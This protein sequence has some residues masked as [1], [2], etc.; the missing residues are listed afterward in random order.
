MSVRRTLIL[1]VLLV[2]ILPAAVVWGYPSLSAANSP[3]LQ[4][5]VVSES[6]IA[7]GIAAYGT[8]EAEEIVNLSFQTSGQV[9]EVLVEDGDWVQAG[10]A[11]IRVDSRT[12]YATYEQANLNYELAVRQLE[13]LQTPDDDAISIAEANLRA[14]QS[15]YADVNNAITDE[16]IAAAQLQYDQAQEALTAAQEARQYAN[17]NVQSDETI[18]LMDAQI[19]EASFNAEIA[20][21]RVEELQTANQGELGAAWA[22]VLQAQAAL[23]Q[24]QSGVTEYQIEQAENAVE[25]AQLTLDQAQ[26]NYDRTMLTAPFD[27][28]VADVTVEVGQRVS[29]GVP[30]VQLVDVDP[31]HFLGE[32]DENNVQ[33]LTQGMNAQVEL[34]AL[35][36]LQFAGTLSQIAPQGRDQNGIVVYDVQIE[37]TTEDGRLRP[38]MSADADL[39]LNDKQDVLIVPVQFVYSDEAGQSYVDVLL[40]DG[41]IEERA[42]TLGIRN[43]NT[44]EIISGLSAGETIVRELA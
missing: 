18:T 39:I 22:N 41:K 42:V 40:A 36:G 16:D 10:D 15:A 34:D 5:Y 27:G 30:I 43:T 37:L 35:P 23:E 8:I 7:T 32:V 38:G 29:A 28:F 33:D 25:Q 1:L 6:E 12:Q 14:A 24:A 44:I 4:T 13:D 3:E 17:P 21:L 20:R 26:V 2:L 9:V 31:L 11:L 19:G